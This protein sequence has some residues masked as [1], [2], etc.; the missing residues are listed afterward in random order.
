MPSKFAQPNPPA[1]QPGTDPDNHEVPNGAQQAASQEREALR[2][3][4]TDAKLA[5]N[6]GGRNNDSSESDNPEGAVHG[7]PKPALK[8][9]WR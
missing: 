5:I 6:E 4:G 7:L 2:Q 8:G 9:T 3:M 1:R